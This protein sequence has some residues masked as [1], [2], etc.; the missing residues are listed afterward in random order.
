M[1]PTPRNSATGASAAAA[2]STPAGETPAAKRARLAAP[3]FLEEH[4]AAHAE[5]AKLADFL[6]ADPASMRANPDALT[7]LN[8]LEKIQA[9]IILKLSAQ[10]RATAD[11]DARAQ[12]ANTIPTYT[13]GLLHKIS[14]VM[15]LDSSLVSVDNVTRLHHELGV[16]LIDS[17]LRKQ[18]LKL[19]Q[20]G[21]NFCAQNAGVEDKSRLKLLV[22]LATNFK[23]GKYLDQAARY[24]TEAYMLTQSQSLTD[25]AR[26]PEVLAGYFDAISATAAPQD[27][28]RVGN[29]LAALMLK[30]NNFKASQDIASLYLKLSHIAIG[31]LDPVCALSL[32][33]MAHSM[34]TTLNLGQ[35]KE[36]ADALQAKVTAYV[37]IGFAD[38]IGWF[39][40]QHLALRAQIGAQELAV[41]EQQPP[42]PWVE[43]ALVRRFSA[44]AVEPSAEGL[45]REQKLI[46]AYIRAHGETAKLLDKIAPGGIEQAPGVLVEVLACFARSILELLPEAIQKASTPGARDD[47]LQREGAYTEDLLEYLFVMRKA[48]PAKVSA[49]DVVKHLYN[50]ALKLSDAGHL[51]RLTEILNMGITFCE[52]NIDAPADVHL[53]LLTLYAHTLTTRGLNQEAGNCFAKAYALS[54]AKNLTNEQNYAYI[55]KSF[56]TS[57]PATASREDVIEVCQAWLEKMELDQ[58]GNPHTDIVDAYCVL[59]KLALDARKASDAA[60]CANLALEMCAGLGL[61]VSQ[62]AA[63]ALLIKAA[64]YRAMGTSSFINQ[65]VRIEHEH[66]LLLAKIE[67]QQA[68]QADAGPSAQL[69]VVT[70]AAAVAPVDMLAA[71]Q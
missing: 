8:A 55:L 38:G 36:A 1:P 68:P 15:Q 28:I 2:S 41:A 25:D 6:F 50:Y 12:L 58:N 56:V 54:K 21:A 40:D 32:A 13:E 53:H 34:L 20:A 3:D 42:A 16:E 52:E 51:A 23:K 10:I 43:E 29:E 65:A 45:T 31:G 27:A 63:D 37:K 30:A 22:S 46:K 67:A 26:Y 57:P 62:P 44:T 11:V 17:G 9:S 48:N 4:I 24:F 70:N 59:A 39:R 60:N 7:I 71:R 66:S 18:G 35:T 49:A 14:L 47:L 69:E 61:S 19:L 64:A 5:V 33:D